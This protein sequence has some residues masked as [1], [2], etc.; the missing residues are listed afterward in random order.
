MFTYGPTTSPVTGA[1]ISTSMPV[2][3]GPV[4]MGG[5]MITVHAAIGQFSKIAQILRKASL[6][7]IFFTLI[8]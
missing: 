1:D 4:A 5:N 8:I 6:F 2:G 7:Q 3:V